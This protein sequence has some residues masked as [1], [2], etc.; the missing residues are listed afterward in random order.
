MTDLILP[1][2]EQPAGPDFILDDTRQ[3]LLK[4]VRAE[5]LG[6]KKWRVDVA[7]VMVPVP[8]GLRPQLMA[9]ASLPSPVLGERILT[10]FLLEAIEAQ[11]AVLSKVAKDMVTALSEERNRVLAQIKLGSRANPN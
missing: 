11:D 10:S 8:G 6:D 3:R 1:G 4:L 7:A 2:A 5:V 9:M